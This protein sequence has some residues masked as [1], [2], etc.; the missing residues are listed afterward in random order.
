MSGQVSGRAVPTAF[1]KSPQMEDR[2]FRLMP[3][4]T[5]YKMKD[6]RVP[7]LHET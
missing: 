7:K 4:V 2:L 1:M 3:T 5:M 6:V